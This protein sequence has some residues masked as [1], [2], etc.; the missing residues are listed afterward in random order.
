MPMETTL[1]LVKPDGVQR[2]LVGKILARFEAKGLQI[3]GLKMRHAPRPLLERHYSDHVG[4]P[5]YPGL[6]EFMSAGPVVAIAVRGRGAIEVVRK[7]MGKT[8]SAE[9]EPGTIRG[10]WG[11]SR[12]FNMIHGSDS[13]A[14]ATK[15][16]AL[17]F[18]PGE[19]LD[20]PLG[21]STWV[22]DPTDDR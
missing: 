15:E 21:S 6:L 9:A 4:K 12:S 22:Y 1:V 16:L 11:M 3:V 13:P 7:A 20:Y 14:N 18:A 2:G 17:W 10:D 19:I 8:N 5:F